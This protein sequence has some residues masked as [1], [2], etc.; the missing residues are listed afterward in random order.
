MVILAA[1]LTLQCGSTI[2]STHRKLCEVTI[3]GIEILTVLLLGV[4]KY[5]DQ[6]SLTLSHY[7]E[8][9][10]TPIY[11]PRICN[12]QDNNFGLAMASIHLSPWGSAP[13]H[14]RTLVL[15]GSGAASLSHPGLR[16]FATQHLWAVH[17]PR[18]FADIAFLR[19]A[20]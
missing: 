15:A 3:R 6:P 2:R 12:C 5:E 8:L 19:R 11:I 16:T 17:T 9:V 7:L 4:F 13:S 18:I 14:L 1:P 20:W 10:E